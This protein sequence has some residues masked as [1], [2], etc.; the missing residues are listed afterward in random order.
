MTA[1]TGSTLVNGA[2]AH[3]IDAADRGLSYGDGV[4]ETIAV[5]EHQPRLWDGHL[6]RLTVG[7]ERLGFEAPARHE[8]LDD[9]SLLALPR[10]G[11]LR[12]SVTRGMGG[13]GYAP[14]PSPRPT[15][16]VRCLDAPT[17]PTE[18]WSPGVAVRFCRMRLAIQPALAGIKHLNRL[19]QVMARQEW[20]TPDI[21]EGL[22]ETTD[23]RVIEATASNL[24]VDQG[25]RLSVPATHDGGVDGVMQTW[26]LD[27]AA[28]LGATVERAAMRRDDLLTARGVM[29]TNSLIGLWPVRT[30]AERSMPHS[31]WADQ[32]QS[33]I[34]RSQAALMP[35]VTEP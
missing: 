25:D 11:V 27:R 26:L 33:E 12:I 19:E 34:T 20:Q 10:F 30:I 35:T 9:L 23:G 24:I 7:C 14:P 18:W 2:P 31:P 3:S 6:Q 5:V 13:R 29:L 28:A 21:A 4:F 22:M 1:D 32:L 16:I 15:R 17:H 8:W